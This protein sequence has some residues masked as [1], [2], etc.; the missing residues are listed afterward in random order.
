M[1][2]L[3]PDWLLAPFPPY[4][5]EEACV[6]SVVVLSPEKLVLMVLHYINN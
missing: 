6:Y 1:Y 4:L 3:P 5:P 2:L